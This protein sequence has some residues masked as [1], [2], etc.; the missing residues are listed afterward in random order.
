MWKDRDFWNEVLPQGHEAIKI[1]HYGPCHEWRGF[2]KSRSEQSRILGSLKGSY[3]T[4]WNTWVA[5]YATPVEKD[6][7]LGPVPGTGR[8]GGQ[9]RQWLDQWY[10]ITT[11]TTIFICHNNIK[12]RTE[13]KMLAGCQ[14]GISLSSWRPMIMSKYNLSINI[15]KKTNKHWE[16]NIKK[17]NN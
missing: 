8:Q 16:K 6:I 17:I 12:M 4:N 1:P 7:M 14:K 15:T 13:C 3:R 9:R 2:E 10:P 5:F 11:T